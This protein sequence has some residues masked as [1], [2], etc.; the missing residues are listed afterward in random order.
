MLNKETKIF[1]ISNMISNIDIHINVI[2]SDTEVWPPEKPSKELVLNDLY[3][4]KAALQIEL[5]S[6]KSS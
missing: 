3:N 5:A 6:V 4:K 2:E 1:I